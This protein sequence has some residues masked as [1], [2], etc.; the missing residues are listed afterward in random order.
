MP[1]ILDKWRHLLLDAME[2]M[3]LPEKRLEKRRESF[4]HASR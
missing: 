2:K 3:P 4:C 1:V